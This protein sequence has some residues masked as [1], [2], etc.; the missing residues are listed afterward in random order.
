VVMDK[1]DC[2]V[3]G[4]PYHRH[5]I[6]NHVLCPIIA[7]YRPKPEA[8]DEITRLNAEVEELRKELSRATGRQRVSIV[9]QDGNEVGYT[10]R[11]MAEL[12]REDAWRDDNGTIWN[13]PTA[14]A[15]F[16]V[17]RARDAKQALIEEMV[18]GLVYVREYLG[19]PVPIGR[20]HIARKVDALI[21]KAQPLME[22]SR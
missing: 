3:C 1:P 2:A 5:N 15:Y 16:A 17:C 21:L 22:D 12:R 20:R 9:D 7:T 6:G 19:D 18:E 13:P 11:P 10:H 8:A 4:L 14:W